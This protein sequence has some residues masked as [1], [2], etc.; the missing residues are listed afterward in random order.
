[1]NETDPCH[2]VGLGGHFKGGGL[3]NACLLYTSSKVLICLGGNLAA[4]A[5]DTEF[6]YE[7]MRRSELNVQIST[8]LNRSHLMVS[9][10]ALILPCLGRTELDQQRSGVQKITVEDTFSTVSY[11]HLL[12][13]VLICLGG[14]VPSFL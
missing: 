9:K 10:D 13:S 5:P 11:T 12:D 6:T 1:M 3:P 14:R 2:G 7:A 4:A 8:K